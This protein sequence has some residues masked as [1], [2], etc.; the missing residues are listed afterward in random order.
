[1][2]EKIG[3]DIRLYLCIKYV[4][5]LNFRPI[6]EGW[7]KSN[8][9]KHFFYFSSRSRWEQWWMREGYKNRFAQISVS[10]ISLMKG[11]DSTANC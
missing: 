10:N 9:K 4:Y 7:K 8:V 3:S 5:A 6:F 2:V 11:V 1:M